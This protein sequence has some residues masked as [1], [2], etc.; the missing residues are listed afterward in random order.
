MMQCGPTNRVSLRMTA[1]ELWYN[2]HRWLGLKIGLEMHKG[3]GH[4]PAKQNRDGIC[5]SVCWLQNVSQGRWE[6]LRQKC[7]ASDASAAASACCSAAH[8]GHLP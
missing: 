1:S 5:R 2:A 4:G 7:S 8:L 6:E 3:V